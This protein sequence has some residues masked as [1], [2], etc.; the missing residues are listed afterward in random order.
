MLQYLLLLSVVQLSSAIYTTVEINRGSH[1]LS[2]LPFFPQAKWTVAV[3]M[4]GDNNLETAITGGEIEYSGSALALSQ[5]HPLVKEKFNPSRAKK[6]LNKMESTYTHKG[7]FHS[8]LAKLG[9]SPDVHVVALIDRGPGYSSEMDDWTNTRLYYVQ[10]NDY[11]DNTRGAYWVNATNHD[12]MNMG[13]GASLTW[14]INTLF[15][16]FPAKFY[17]LTM[18]DHNWGWHPEYFQQDYTNEH[19]SLTYDELKESLATL[20][21][22]HIIRPNPQMEHPI[23]I[24]GYDACVGA[25]IEVMHTWSN[26]AK[27]FVGSQDYVG[28]EGINYNNV[29]SS[30]YS[31]T[32][33]TPE[34]VSVI[35]A[36]SMME[37]PDDNC[38]SVVHFN[39]SFH[40]L[41]KYID[42]LAVEF[43]KEFEDIQEVLRDIHASTAYVPKVDDDIVHKDLKIL[44]QQV[45]KRLSN[46]HSIVTIARK[47][48]Q[49]FSETVIYNS[50]LKDR[51][52]E[53][54]HGISIYWPNTASNFESAYT[55]TSFADNTH[56]DEFLKLYLNIQ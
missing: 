12:E 37:D 47:A 53:N 19:D 49:E 23:N 39:P 22:V 13:D 2:E 4:N 1:S 25:Q 40:D 7:D 55:K 5:R 17:F 35:A 8:E 33:I 46:Y 38:V 27:F 31:N 43:I 3:Y 11:P 18:W 34:D 21:P 50:A 28:W 29:I 51:T 45:N 41:V 24:V 10:E 48:L 20:P 42:Q 54:G 16:H 52:C 44:L 26:Y 6:N 9:S 32:S 30:I 15:K 56:W 36:K 14:Y